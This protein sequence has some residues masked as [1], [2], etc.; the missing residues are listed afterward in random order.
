MKYLITPALPYING[1][2][3]LGNLVGSM[4]PGD[5]YARFLRRQGH[6]VL[7]ICGTDEHGT[8]AEIAAQEAGKSVKDYCDDL[9]QAQKETYEQFGISF[10]HF[11]R[12][13]APS[14]HALT[15]EIFNA[16]DAN[17]FIEERSTQQYY[18]VDDGRFLPD[19]YVMGT[20][21][22]CDYEKARGD[23][24]D[25]CGHLL[26]PQELK[27]PYSSI[28]GSRNLELRD[29]KH[30]FLLL[31]RMEDQLKEW[32]DT[33]TD[34][35]AMT[36]G[37]AYKWLKEGLQ[38]R[39]I[40]R[41]LSWGIPVP[42][43]GY[44]GKV[45]Y[46][47]FDAPIAYISITQSAI[48][49]DYKNWWSKK[50]DTCYVEFMAKDNV[51]F[52]TIF[53]PAMLLASGMDIRLVDYLKSVSWLNYDGGKFSTS[54]KRGVFLDQALDLFPA[55]YWRYYLMVCIPE[56]DDTDFTFQHFADVINKD[57]VG[58]LGNFVNRVF[59]LVHKYSPDG[60]KTAPL[61]EALQM[62]ISA[63]LKQHS[64]A[65]YALKFRHAMEALRSLWRL[66]NSYIAEQEPWKL[67]ADQSEIALSV[68]AHCLHLIHVYAD[69]MY[70]IMPERAAFVLNLLGVIPGND[71][72]EWHIKPAALVF[73]KI[74][75]E[76]V[77]ELT[78]RF[79]GRV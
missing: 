34:W 37:I 28:S 69:A 20:C 62:G 31:N 71:N 55:D 61:P 36:K 72:K 78:Q 9:F 26:D 30:L 7:Y 10:D 39:C 4:L 41:D 65:L 66:G 2:K 79:S 8:P 16:L 63:L 40:T 11:G 25:G 53:F 43:D 77:D 58:G 19:R 49:E 73:T 13:S 33:K 15:I 12:S 74:Q 64:D 45:F 57:L 68:L 56:T 5:V 75:Q 51:P 70:P 50:N 3:H 67:M 17:G 6:D 23:Q 47:W 22:H 42:K 52:H 24:C 27:N 44:E 60:L 1:I 35:P 21:P 38:P 48:G 54:Q 46:V 29:S 14:N 76:T 18:C 59:T 32:M